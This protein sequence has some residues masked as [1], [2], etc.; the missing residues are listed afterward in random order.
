MDSRLEWIPAEIL[1]ERE[2]VCLV[3]ED[4]PDHGILLQQLCAAAFPQ[5][6]TLFANSY[7]EGL[8]DAHQ[9]PCHLVLLST[10]VG[11]QYDDASLQDFMRV[12]A[13]I[14]I[15]AL[16]PSAD[17]AI[18]SALLRWGASACFVK[19]LETLHE[20]PETIDRLTRNTRTSAGTGLSSATTQSI[21]ALLDAI[22]VQL[23]SLPKR[24]QSAQSV[25]AELSLLNKEL[26]LLRTVLGS[27]VPNTRDDHR[28]PR[29]TPSSKP[30]K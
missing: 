1:S 7:A 22:G 19:T 18:R 2:F 10:H 12:L 26:A 28:A 4:N 20:L 13:P 14:P 23:T 29:E 8:H 25:R 6:T 30:L 3:V 15:I 9:Q 16:M 21:T 27:L 5:A 17:R 11:D 24:L